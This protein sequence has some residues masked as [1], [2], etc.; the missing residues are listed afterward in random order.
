Y[1]PPSFPTRRSSDLLAAEDLILY[2]E[3]GGR[4]YVYLPEIVTG[5]MTQVDRDK[6]DELYITVDD[7]DEYRQSYILDAAS[8][9]DPD[10]THFD[11]DRKS[12][13]LNSSHVS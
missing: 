11:I 3:Y 7:A 2:V 6:S 13:R 12:T 8:L 1:S 10:L 5:T 4:T 9:A